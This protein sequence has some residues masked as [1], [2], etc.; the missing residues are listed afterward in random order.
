MKKLLI[1]ILLIITVVGWNFAQIAEI[2]AV[3]T[4]NAP[5]AEKNVC[6]I[7]KGSFLIELDGDYYIDSLVVDKTVCGGQIQFSTFI[8]G[9]FIPI[10]PNPQPHLQ[11]T[12]YFNRVTKWIKVEYDGSDSR[13]SV[14]FYLTRV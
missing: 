9:K 3:P 2:Q 1:T 10:T 7:P 6:T 11:Q 13:I 12:Y 4:P 8:E 5:S 14:M